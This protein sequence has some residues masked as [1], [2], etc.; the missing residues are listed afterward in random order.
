MSSIVVGCYQVGVVARRPH[1]RV[2]L[3]DDEVAGLAMV[4]VAM[5]WLCGTTT[6]LSSGI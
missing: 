6:K 4:V 3:A 1:W 2:V 5:C